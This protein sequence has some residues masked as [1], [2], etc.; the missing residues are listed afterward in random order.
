MT[1]AR[2]SCRHKE[3]HTMFELYGGIYDLCEKC[4]LD[5]PNHIKEQ[6]KDENGFWQPLSYFECLE[7]LSPEQ[8]KKIR[9][10]EK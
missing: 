10:A 7:K 2:T 1:G 6:K 5:L 3:K 4:K 9:D 8:R